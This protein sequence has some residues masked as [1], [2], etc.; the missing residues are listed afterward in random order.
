MSVARQILDEI[1]PRR[2]RGDLSSRAFFVDNLVFV[3]HLIVASEPILRDCA[4]HG[5]HTLTRYFELHLTEE[6]NHADWLRRDL[7]TAGVTTINRRFQFDAAEIAGAQYYLARHGMVPAVL[8]YLLAL[9]G[10]PMPMQVVAQLEEIHGFGMCRTLR[11]H[12][13]SDADHCADLVRVVDCIDPKFTAAIRENAIRTVDGIARSARA[14]G[15][16]A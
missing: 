12:A 7:E 4:F 5:P 6:R 11:H 8:G 15:I 10:E 2:P 14:F 9:E 13:F 16:P 3:Y 1:S